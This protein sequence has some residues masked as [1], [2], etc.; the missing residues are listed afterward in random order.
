MTD[1]KETWTVKSETYP[2]KTYT[3]TKKDDGYSCSCPNWVYRRNQC[4]HI[5]AVR[6]GRIDYTPP[7][8]PI[9]LGN[10][11]EV[12]ER[13]ADILVPLIPLDHNMTDV[14]ATALY[15][16]MSVGISWGAAREQYNMVPKEWTKSAVIDH[17]LQKGRLIWVRRGGML[18][19]GQYTR[20]GVTKQP[21]ATPA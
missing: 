6:D 2:D 15:D 14:L 7:H 17:V 3:V 4:K 21:V 10:V 12:T 18:R 8:K 9:L 11:G 5:L 16:L 20:A 1:T 13:K 19:G